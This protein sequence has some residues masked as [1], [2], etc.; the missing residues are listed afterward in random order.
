MNLFRSLTC[1]ATLSLPIM[2]G[3]P[4][5]SQPAPMEPPGKAAE[6][7]EQSSLPSDHFDA[8]YNM[9]SLSVGGIKLSPAAKDMMH[10][11][12]LQG[13][14]Q[15]TDFQELE[16]QFPGV[17]LALV[18]TVVPVAIRQTEET[19]PAL[20]ERLAR[21]YAEEMTADEIAVATKWY[22]SP[23]YSRVSAA[24]EANMDLS[25]IIQKS[26]ADSDGRVSD[27]DLEAVNRNSAA[28]SASAMELADRSV[29]MRFSATSAFAKIEAL[30]P[31]SL[32]IEAEWT[33]E[34]NPDHDAELEALTIK[35][36][37]EFTGMDLSE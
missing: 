26:I 11:Q 31:K 29:L 28:Q 30:K 6:P 13:F 20:I 3:Q 16:Q 17:T 35:V 22:S 15:D 18:D 5:L 23:A 34:D 37:E 14:A 4:A 12:I 1:F 9:T 32:M 24:M 8:A 10:E 19:M 33:N 7:G 21:L 25:Q 36:L 27:M 2:A